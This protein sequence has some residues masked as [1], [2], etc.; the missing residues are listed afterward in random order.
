MFG[1]KKKLIINN[2]NE[3]KS[4]INQRQIENAINLKKTNTQ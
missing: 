4:K 3:I 2:L 1:L